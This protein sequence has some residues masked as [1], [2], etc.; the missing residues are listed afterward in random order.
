MLNFYIEEG[1]FTLLDLNDK[2]KS[3][4]YGYSYCKNKPSPILDRDLT[5]DASTNLGQTASQMWN[6]CIILPFVLKE[7]N[8]DTDDEKWRCLMSLIELLSLILAHKISFTVVVYIKRLITKHLQ[9][10]KKLYGEVANIIPKQHYLIH[11]PSLILKYGPLRRSW[12]MRFEGK[13]AFFKDEANIVRNFKNLPLSLSKRYL[14]SLYADHIKLGD[15]DK[16]PL[17]MQS[18]RFGGVKELHGD[19]RAN[20]VNVIERFYG[21]GLLQGK[22]VYRVGSVEILGILYKPSN[23]AFLHFGYYNSLPEFG[24][25][26]RIWVSNT[27]VYIALDVVLT[28]NYDESVNAFKF[29]DQEL[30]QG[31][32][33]V[34]PCDLQSPF[35]YNSYQSYILTKVNPIAW[36]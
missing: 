18:K 5:R 10:F 36:Q 2:I 13:H 19:E 15:A 32:Q 35:V 23:K 22:E 7:M 3:F 21:Q 17:F 9:I 14:T 8:I 27:E 11:L 26:S 34:K 1:F 31:Y 4:P 28:L 6:L 24:R 29:E 20:A 33:I 12:C 25:I 16:S 30:P